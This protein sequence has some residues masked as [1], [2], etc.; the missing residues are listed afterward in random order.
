VLNTT[1]SWLF[2]AVFGLSMASVACGSKN[3]FDEDIAKSI[4]EA[5]AV[6]LDGE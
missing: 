5:K 4:L 1:R 6:N 2:S 3:D